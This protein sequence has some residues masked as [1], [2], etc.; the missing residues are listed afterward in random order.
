M[1]KLLSVCHG[2]E[3]QTVDYQYNS[4]DDIAN[5]NDS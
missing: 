3:V 1:K 2:D 5:A 4:K